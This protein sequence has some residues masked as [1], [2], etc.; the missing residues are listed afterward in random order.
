MKNTNKILILLLATSFKGYG[1]TINV[2]DRIDQSEF[3]GVTLSRAV[4]YSGDTVC[5]KNDFKNDEVTLDC[6]L[7]GAKKTIYIYAKNAT[8]DESNLADI[9]IEN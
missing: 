9:S 5:D 7:Q 8:G 4:L 2:N 1:I 6:A 3:P